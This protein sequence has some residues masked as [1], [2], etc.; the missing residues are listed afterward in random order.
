MAAD[1]QKMSNLSVKVAEASVDPISKQ[2]NA[3]VEKISKQLAA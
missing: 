1:F 2:V 3:V